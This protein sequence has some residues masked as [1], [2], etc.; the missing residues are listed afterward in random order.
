MQRVRGDRAPDMFSKDEKNNIEGFAYWPGLTY[1]HMDVLGEPS[2]KQNYFMRAYSF[3]F[4]LLFVLL[5][6]KKL[7]VSKPVDPPPPLLKLFSMM[8]SL[9]EAVKN[10]LADFSR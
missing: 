8:A 4:L 3:T 6:I 9:R 5:F 2:L 7:E 1:S 10:Y